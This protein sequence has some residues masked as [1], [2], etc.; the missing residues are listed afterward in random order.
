MPLPSSL[1]TQVVTRHAL[2]REVATC[3]AVYAIK[4]VHAHCQACASLVV[5]TDLHPVMRP[6]HGGKVRQPGVFGEIVALQGARAKV[7]LDLVQLRVNVDEQGG[8][9]VVLKLE[10]FVVVDC[11]ERFFGNVN[12]NAPARVAL[13]D[14]GKVSDS[15]AATR[16]P[17][18]HTACAVPPS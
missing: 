14:V 16:H 5:R 8:P 13:L 9:R 4:V 1:G 12:R 18:T 3:V 7:L 17:A 6:V 15:A 10:P 11:R 2:G